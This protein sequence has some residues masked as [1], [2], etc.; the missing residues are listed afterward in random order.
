MRKTKFIGFTEIG[1]VVGLILSFILFSIVHEKTEAGEYTP[2]TNFFGVLF[3]LLLLAVV[4]VGSILLIVFL[5]ERSDKKSEA[6]LANELAT[7]KQLLDLE[8]E[9][10]KRLA[11]IE[12]EKQ[13]KLY[14][15]ERRAKENNE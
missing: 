11:E 9:R 1:L 2:I 6:K 14:E 10:Q 15:L 3:M 13:K 8:I 12:V 7:Q 5:T 4:I